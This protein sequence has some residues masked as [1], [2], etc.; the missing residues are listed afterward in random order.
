[1]KNLRFPLLFLSALW[2]MS[3]CAASR[4]S[5]VSQGQPG[6][7]D[8][9]A[10]LINERHDRKVEAIRNG[11]YDVFMIGNSITQTLSDEDGEWEP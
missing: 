6:D 7:A 1:M 5:A 9:P 11:H 3:G 10:P 4:T 2:L 8:Y